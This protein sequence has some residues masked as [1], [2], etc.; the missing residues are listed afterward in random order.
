MMPRLIVEATGSHA[1]KLDFMFW[2]GVV[3]YVL[4]LAAILAKVRR[5]K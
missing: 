1:R 2:Y 4:F 3:T 5:V